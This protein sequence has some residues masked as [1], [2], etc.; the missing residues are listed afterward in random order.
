MKR[1][2]FW[3]WIIDS[4]TPPGKRRKTS[5]LMT[6]EQAQHYGNPVKVGEPVMREVREPGDAWEGHN[7]T[8]GPTGKTDWN[9]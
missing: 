7:P 2:P 8:Y 9:R 6:E 4:E 5:W 3:Y 1:V